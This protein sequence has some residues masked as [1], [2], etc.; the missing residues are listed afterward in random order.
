MEHKKT[1]AVFKK[2]K[3]LT[4]E[5]KIVWKE[6]ADGNTFYTS[7]NDY[8]IYIGKSVG[9]VAFE[10]FNS[11]YEKIGLLEQGG[12]SQNTPGLDDFYDTVRK[13]VLK[14]DDDLDE[15][16]SRLEGLD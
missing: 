5:H 2:I 4:A 15:L 7:V 8:K 12:Y 14:I 16:L 3:D 6:E 13:R 10:L 1:L 11:Q 9:T